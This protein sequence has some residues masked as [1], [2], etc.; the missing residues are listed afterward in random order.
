MAQAPVKVETVLDEINKLKK[1]RALELPEQL[2]PR[3]AR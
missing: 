1:L 3:R 2:V